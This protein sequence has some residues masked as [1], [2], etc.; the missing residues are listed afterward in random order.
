MISKA[1]RYAQ[2]ITFGLPLAL[3]LLTLVL[4]AIPATRNTAGTSLLAILVGGWWVLAVL[5]INA[6]V[7]QVAGVIAL[8]KARSFAAFY[9]PGLLVGF[10]VPLIIAGA[11]KKKP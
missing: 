3:G 10:L 1:P 5:F 9:F 4:L 11:V 2:I 6:V 8:G 7:S